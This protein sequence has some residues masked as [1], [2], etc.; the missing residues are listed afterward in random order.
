MFLYHPSTRSRLAY[1]TSLYQTKTDKIRT[2]TISSQFR[3][4]HARK[5]IPQSDDTYL[6]TVQLKTKLVQ[7]KK[8][9]TIKQTVEPGNQEKNESSKDAVTKLQQ[10]P[11]QQQVVTQTVP[12]KNIKITKEFENLSKRL[13]E[14]ELTLSS[15]RK[16]LTPERLTKLQLEQLHKEYEEEHKQKPSQ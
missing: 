15:I 7:L 3:N 11:T 16:V 2:K 14:T 4:K 1:Q 12:E 13:A 10:D 5:A 6:T 9:L 8:F